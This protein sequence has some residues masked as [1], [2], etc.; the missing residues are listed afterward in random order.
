MY[1]LKLLPDTNCFSKFGIERFGMINFEQFKE[2][3]FPNMNINWIKNKEEPADLLICGINSYADCITDNNKINILICIENIKNPQVTWYKHYNNYGE[4]NNSAIKLYIYN[5]INKIKKTD[6][7]L[8]LPCIYFRMNYFKLN[9][10]YYFNH[11]RLNVNF[12]DKRFCL[13]I[14][15]SGFNKANIDIVRNKLSSIGQVDYINMYD[16]YILDKSCY[17][18]IELLEVFNQYKFIIC[19]EN[20]YNSG[21]ITE[22]IFNVFFSKSIPIYS[23][24]DMVQK[25]FNTNTFINVENTSQLNIDLVRSLNT[26]ENL[27]NTYIKSEKI[28]NTYDDENF[29]EEMQKFIDLNV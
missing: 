20:S 9:Y 18:S 26:D 5:H 7:Y 4:Y 12:K 24:S 13:T 19:F 11:P 6:H 15:K 1:N 3:F 25:Y 28:N 21:Y 22:K 8:A 16:N 17:N 29:L 27:Y 10:N 23:G 14:N 2:Y